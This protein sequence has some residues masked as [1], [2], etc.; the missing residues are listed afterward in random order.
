MPRSLQ[1][2]KL[3][4]TCIALQIGEGLTNFSLKTN[5]Y[6]GK[7]ALETIPQTL[8]GKSLIWEIESAP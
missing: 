8:P 1:Y 4:A 3:L 2:G 6:Q 7:K 5:R